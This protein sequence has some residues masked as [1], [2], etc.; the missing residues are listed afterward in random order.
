M[1][2]SS[3]EFRRLEQQLREGW[4]CR[5]LVAARGHNR[6][7][8]AS[9]LAH[10]FEGAI[11]T[12]MQTCFPGFER[13][14]PPFLSS[15]GRIDKAGRVVADIWEKDGTIS[16]NQVIFPNSFAYRDAMRRLAD[17]LRFSDAERLEFFTC[18]K[19]WLVAD[20]RL[21]PTMDPADPDAK[22][23]TVH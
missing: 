12:I 7:I 19:R 10:A 21:D 16:K 8:V 22:H 11:L 5:A 4:Q 18:V 17:R 9:I 2:V 20:L 3:L 14:K 23:F 13:L 6:A 1:E 15:A